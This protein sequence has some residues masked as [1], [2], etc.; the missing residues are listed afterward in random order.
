MK[1]CTNTIGIPN[2]TTIV[3]HE[4]NMQQTC[5]ACIQ[6][7]VYFTIYNIIPVSMTGT[8]PQTF[9]LHFCIHLL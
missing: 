9:P 7:I 3:N 8:S 4:N 2:K 5:L 1:D 6:L